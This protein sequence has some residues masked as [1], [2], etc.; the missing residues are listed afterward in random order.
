MNPQQL[1]STETK[2][3]ILGAF[4]KIGR[5]ASNCEIV[6]FG[7]IGLDGWPNVRVLLVAARDGVDTIW[8]ATGADSKKIAELKANP[9]ATIYGYDGEAMQEF[10]L[11]G[12]VDMRTDAEARQKIWRDD[13]IE[14]FPGGMD[15]PDMVVLQFKTES[16]FFDSYMREVGTF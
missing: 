9:K 15:S 10:R 12:Q 8:F 3:R 5:C 16:G 14:H 11:F 13:F 2:E 7:T 1:N 6:S 4:E